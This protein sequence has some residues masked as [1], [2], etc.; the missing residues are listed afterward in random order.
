M[1]PASNEYAT[2]GLFWNK[3]AIPV[4]SSSTTSSP[5]LNFCRYRLGES[6]FLLIFGVSLLRF[7]GDVGRLFPL[8]DPLPPKLLRL[9]LPPP[10]PPPNPLFPPLLPPFEY[11]FCGSVGGLGA[12]GFFLNNREGAGSF[13][14]FFP[15]AAQD[16][17][18]SSGSTPTAT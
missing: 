13:L 3:P 17:G 7:I 15:A 8:W 9:K 1:P 4:A 2:A 6:L 12:S 5:L 18:V 16:I 14:L 10:N 11:G